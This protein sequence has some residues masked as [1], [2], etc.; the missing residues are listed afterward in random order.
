[1]HVYCLSNCGHKSRLISYNILFIQDVVHTYIE[2]FFV[3]SLYNHFSVKKKKK[4]NYLSTLICVNCGHLF[5]VIFQ[6]QCLFRTIELTSLCICILHEP[7]KKKLVLKV[8][9]MVLYNIYNF[10]AK[11][12]S[13]MVT[14]AGS[15]K[16]MHKELFVRNCYLN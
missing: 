4:K 8:S 11:R 10:C 3:V 1:M 5:L 6:V 15:N 7:F 2:L 9:W 14:T 13:K 16:K 12:K